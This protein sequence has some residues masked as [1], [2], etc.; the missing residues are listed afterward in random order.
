MGIKKLGRR[1]FL[2]EKEDLEKK[3]VSCDK[4]LKISE[5]KKRRKKK[6]KGLNKVTK[7]KTSQLNEEQKKK[8][9]GENGQLMLIRRK[10]P[11][12]MTP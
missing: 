11:G 1:I 2:P 5:L 6:I 7:E 3:T 9:G 10:Q 8:T 4:N 12:V